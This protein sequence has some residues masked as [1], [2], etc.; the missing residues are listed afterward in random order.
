M[1]AAALLSCLSP[2]P[3]IPHW[4]EVAVGKYHTE[5]EDLGLV[6]CQ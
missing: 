4:T 5:A 2:Q 1:G 6:S 3:V